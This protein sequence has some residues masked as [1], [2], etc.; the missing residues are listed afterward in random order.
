MSA[1]FNNKIA[2][3]IVSIAIACLSG[4]QPASLGEAQTAAP[5]VAGLSAN[6]A[7]ACASLIRIDPLLIDSTYSEPVFWSLSVNFKSFEK[8]NPARP[9]ACLKV[10][11]LDRKQGI[12]VDLSASRSG[13]PIRGCRVIGNVLM[14]T[15]TINNLSTAFGVAQFAGKSGYVHCKIDLQSAVES[16]YKNYLISALPDGSI[17]QLTTFQT[18]HSYLM[19]AAGAVKQPVGS[20]FI[21]YQPGLNCPVDASIRG[22]KNACNSL[23][24]Q[25]NARSGLLQHE[26]A[27]DGGRNFTPQIEND[28]IQATTDSC[29][30]RPA[31]VADPV[32]WWSVVGQETVRKSDQRHQIYEITNTNERV[33][34]NAG[35]YAPIAIP[36]YTGASDLYIGGLPNAV[37][38]WGDLYEVVID[39]GSGGRGTDN[40]K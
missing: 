9:Y 33:S 34:C 36:F 14:G 32:V 7:D 35:V 27:A 30:L 21:S 25:L 29:L 3:R 5:P 31:A 40:V 18:L 23:G 15:T 17:P 16:A 37:S 1:S 38:A 28:L 20:A 12:Y 19:A 13:V 4:M 6:L 11:G 24:Y 10:F 39:P 26:T 8:G 22:L 2:L